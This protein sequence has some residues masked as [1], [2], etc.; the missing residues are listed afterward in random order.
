[1]FPL[2]TVGIV[3]LNREWII[4]KMFD[5]LINQTYP[6]DSLFI[7]VVDSESKDKTVEIAR[8]YLSSADFKGHEI[9]IKK[10]SIPE[11][12]NICIEKMQGDLLMFWDSDVILEPTAVMSLFETLKKEGADIATANT[13]D[14]F[15][16]SIEDASK[17]L[18]EAKTK[19]NQKEEGWFIDSVRMGQTIIT[20]NLLDTIKF[21]PDLTSLEDCDFSIRAKEKNFKMVMNKGILAL[22]VNVISLG[23]S[24]I[25]IDMPLRYALRGIGK[26]SKVQLL[27]YR[28][29]LTFRDSINFFFLCKRY[30]FYLGYIPAA[31]LSLNGIFAQNLFILIFPLYLLVFM[32]RQFK[33]RGIMKGVKAT[34]RSILIGVPSSLALVYYSFKY[35]L[36]NMVKYSEKGKTALNL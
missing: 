14:I 19:F 24:D 27:R 9:I 17:K 36:K 32:L 1:V 6:H 16:D 30:I 20:K 5:C 35:S 26:K 29:P 13:I 31:I 11:G 3:V 28:P 21:D 12:R 25:Y 18:I 33:R 2:I 8:Q 10:C 23:H 34:V 15:G 7:L 22:D 4:G